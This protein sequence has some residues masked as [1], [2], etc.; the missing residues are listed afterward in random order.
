[1]LNSLAAFDGGLGKNALHQNNANLTSF[2]QPRERF[3]T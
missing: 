1:V 2:F 3:W